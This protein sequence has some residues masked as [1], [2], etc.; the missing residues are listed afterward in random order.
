MMSVLVHP[1]M[2][3]FGSWEFRV[4]LV[5][6]SSYDAQ[7][8]VWFPLK[9]NIVETATVLEVDD[10]LTEVID[11]LRDQFM[12][13]IEVE[14]DKDLII[15]LGS[16]ITQFGQ[17][18]DYVDYDIVLF[19]VRPTSAESAMALVRDVGLVNDYL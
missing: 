6:L 8:Y 5:V 1:D 3:L 14:L 13:P 15:D 9:L 16:V 12:F 2:T 19:D 4:R 7:S 17:Q 11:T 18:G 10:G